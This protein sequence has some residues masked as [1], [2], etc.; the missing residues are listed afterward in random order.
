LLDPCD[1]DAPYTGIKTV[2]IPSITIVG[3]SYTANV[4][5]NASQVFNWKSTDGIL[6]VYS[7][8]M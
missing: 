1:V 4:N 2:N 6:T 3:D 8:A 5:N 7:G